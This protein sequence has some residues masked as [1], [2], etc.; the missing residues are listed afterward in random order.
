MGHMWKGLGL[1]LTLV[2]PAHR[3][4]VEWDSDLRRPQLGHISPLEKQLKQA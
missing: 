3:E 1:A 4:H 2:S